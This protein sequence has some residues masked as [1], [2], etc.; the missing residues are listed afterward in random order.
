[1]LM[2]LREYRKYVE[3]RDG[4]GTMKSYKYWTGSIILKSKEE[5]A[6]TLDFR[7]KVLR[8]DKITK[9]VEKYNYKTKRFQKVM[10]HS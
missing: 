4:A 8:Q 6:K 3:L 10:H 2:K 5:V 7:C 9:E 1:M